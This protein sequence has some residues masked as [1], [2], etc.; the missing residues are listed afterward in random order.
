M[1]SWLSWLFGWR[2]DWPEFVLGILFG[3]LVAWG[4][5]R[6]L[7]SVQ[8]ATT[9]TKQRAR[10]VSDGFTAGAK[11][12]YREELIRRV[13]TLHLARAILALEE[14]A[15]PPRLLAPQP[16]ADPQRSESQ[17]E[18]SMAVLPNLP[19]TNVLSGIYRAPTLSL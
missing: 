8:E 14:I 11:D 16:P 6:A 18:G 12:R 7:P 1:L 15:V 2:F 13:E 19:E 4:I 10:T 5:R 17:P 9:W 3:L